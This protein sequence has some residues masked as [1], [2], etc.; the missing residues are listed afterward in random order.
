MAAIQGFLGALDESSFSRMHEV[1]GHRGSPNPMH[2][3]RVAGLG[4]YLPRFKQCENRFEHGGQEYLVGF[5]GDIFNKDSLIAIL[6]DQQVQLSTADDTEVVLK[7]Y[8]TFG[9]MFPRL[10][11]GNFALAIVSETSAYIARDMI[12]VRP[13]F[14]HFTPERFTFGSEIKSLL[15]TIDTPTLDTESLYERYVFGDHLVGNSTYISGI[16]TILPGHYIE[17]TK[18][19]DTLERA[20]GE[21]GQRDWVMPGDETELKKV[22]ADTVRRNVSHYAQLPTTVGVL[23]SGGFDSSVITALASAENAKLKTFT[24]SDDA[25]FPDVMAARTVAAHCRTD[26]HEHILKETASLEDLV[27]GIHAYED[28]IFRDTIFKLAKGVRGKVGVAMSGAGAD[29]LGMPI[30]ARPRSMMRVQTGMRNLPAI[31]A[32]M[33]FPRERVDTYL[34]NFTENLLRNKDAAI[35]KHYVEDYIPRQLLPSTERA[36]MYHGIEPAFPFADARV[37]AISRALPPTL[38]Y[39]SNEEKP[40]LREAFSFVDLP[41]EIMHREKVCSKTNLTETKERTK[42]LVAGLMPDAFSDSHRFRTLLRDDKYLIASFEMFR[43]MF[44]ENR[45]ARMQNADTAIRDLFQPS[46]MQLVRAT[47]AR[48]QHS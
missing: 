36:L 27:A 22:L 23:L 34:R 37:L 30:L 18:H 7:L 4:Q 12:G 32:Q 15:Q 33:K 28:V 10:I 26:H 47:A 41:T 6:R 48:H 19:G 2:Y 16:K 8:Q 1:V 13:L 3:R 43:H 14:Y 44:I 25:A 20:D 29:L 46:F 17:I 5:D 38:K 11:E 24:I 21:Y 31:Q 39:T 9:N 45:G 42:N 40:F 35:F